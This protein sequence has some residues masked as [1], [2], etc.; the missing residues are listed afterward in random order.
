MPYVAEINGDT[1]SYKERRA[2]QQVAGQMS[3]TT[4]VRTI[5]EIL[6][7]KSQRRALQ[8]L[9]TIP[10]TERQAAVRWLP[11]VVLKLGLSFLGVT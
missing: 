5:E 3:T 10:E 11:C 9:G 7:D 4:R 1:S 8:G 2:P 6:A